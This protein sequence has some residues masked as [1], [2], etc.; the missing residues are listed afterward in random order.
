MGQREWMVVTVSDAGEMGESS[1]TFPTLA[2]LGTR[3]QGYF[4]PCLFLSLHLF[5]RLSFQCS[6]L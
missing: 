5:W 3:R 6:L 4:C 2:F 1:C